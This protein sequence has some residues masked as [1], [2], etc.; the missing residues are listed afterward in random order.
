MGTTTARQEWALMWPLPLASMMG[1]SSCAMFAFSSGVFME[2]MTGAFGWTRA[3][4]SST[5]VIMMGLGLFVGPAVGWLIDRIGPRRVALIGIL[6]FVVTF[7]MLGLASGPLWQWSALCVLFAVFQIALGQVTWVTAVISRFEASRGLALA[8][9]LAG[10]GLGSFVWPQLAAIYI[11]RLGWRLAFPAMALTW[12]IVA[13]PLILAFFYGANDRSALPRQKQVRRPYG[14]AIRSRSFIGLVLAGGL[15]AS[16]YFGLQVHLV[17]LLKSG[18]MTLTSAAGIVGLIGIFSVIGRLATGHFLDHLPTRLIGVVAF[19]L[20]AVSALLLMLLPGSVPAAIAAVALLGLASGA[21]LD[22]ITFIA[23]RRFGRD[24]FGSIYALFMAIISVCA[25]VG[26]VVAGSLF[27]ATGSYH[28]F[29]VYM[30]AAVVTA[31]ALI[32]WIPISSKLET[33]PVPATA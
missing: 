6:P 33:T 24:V 26:P 20:P 32:A 12:M 15:F 30:V 3:Q 27:D 17:P 1:I 22:I 14:P 13:L 11:E 4:F 10:L 25:S 28:G 9:T 8:V 7:S 18:G 31:A 5:F 16:A 21:E 23:A 19:L 29:L 2:E